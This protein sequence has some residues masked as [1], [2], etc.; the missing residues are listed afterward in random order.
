V[1]SN[2]LLSLFDRQMRRDA[3]FGDPGV[4][5]ERD[6]RIVLVSGEDGES[7]SAVIWSDLDEST[8]D[9]A[10]ARAAARLRSLGPESE[11][12]LYAHDRPADLAA[13]LLAAGLEPGA[14]E[15]VLVAELAGLGPEPGLPPALPPG[16]ELR[17]VTSAEDAAAVAAVQAEIF[18]GDHGGIGRLLLRALEHDPPPVLG[19]VALAGGSPVSAARVDFNE[20]S[21]FASIWGGGTLPAW[22]GRGLYRATVA[23]RA[24]LARE[25]GYR[26]LQVDALPTSRP[27]LERLGFVQLTTTTP[28]RAAA[29]EAQTAGRSL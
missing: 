8:A 18:G 11:W 29:R 2:A 17:V 13:R 6:E 27:I 24:R 20:G 10:I 26:Y 25:R 21:D 9:E 15:A 22:R 12:K 23:L 1:D 7:W 28:Y 5:I 4:R 16:V 3:A 19:V 14:E